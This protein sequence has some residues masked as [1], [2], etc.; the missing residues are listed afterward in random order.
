MEIYLPVIPSVDNSFKY[1][2]K[3]DIISSFSFPKGYLLRTDVSYHFWGL[4]LMPE[5]EWRK[6][7]ERCKDKEEQLN[8]S[9]NTLFDLNFLESS[10]ER[11]FG[12]LRIFDYQPFKKVEP[13]VIKVIH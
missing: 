2:Y 3:D 10:L 12:A 4:D 6:F 8:Q 13:T 5:L 9:R 7:M 11:G 1:P